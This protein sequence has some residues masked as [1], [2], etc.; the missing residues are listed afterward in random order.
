MVA[1]SNHLLQLMK[2]EQ[3]HAQDWVDLQAVAVQQVSAQQ[4]QQQADEIRKQLGL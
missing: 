4:E 2:L 1:I 3:K